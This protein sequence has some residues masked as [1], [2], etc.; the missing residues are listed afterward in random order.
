ML[1][2]ISKE[3][4]FSLVNDIPLYILFVH[5]PVY[6]QYKLFPLLEHTLLCLQASI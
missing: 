1:Q 4:S 3:H 5:L 6:G 2:Y